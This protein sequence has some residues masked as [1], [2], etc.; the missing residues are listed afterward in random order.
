MFK[1]RTVLLQTC[2]RTRI[3][4]HSVHL[5]ARK[6]D[7]GTLVLLGR[8]QKAVGIAPPNN[9]TH[10][11]VGACTRGYLVIT[12]FA[13]CCQCEKHHRNQLVAAIP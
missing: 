3:T 5:R 1:A 9:I 7:E 13:A 6:T 2:I 8:I 10:T 12:E 4:R 11:E